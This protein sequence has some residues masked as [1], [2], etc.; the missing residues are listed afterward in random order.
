MPCL[1][2]RAYRD[3]ANHG[4]NYED[5]FDRLRK[6]RQIN[7]SAHASRAL[8]RA[9]MTSEGKKRVGEKSGRY[10]D[11]LGKAPGSFGDWNARPGRLLRR[12]LRCDRLLLR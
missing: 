4:S 2:L 12:L 8:K 9:T 5:G 6:F 10:A 1:R 11:L 7:I 3:G